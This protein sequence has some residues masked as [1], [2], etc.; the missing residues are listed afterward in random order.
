MNAIEIE[1]TEE[2]YRDL[3]DEIYGDV[4]VCGM[5]FS[6]GRALQELDPV[7]F[8]CGLS[9]YS[10]ENQRWKCG[11]CDEEFDNEDDAEACCAPECS[12]CGGAD[13]PLHTSGKCPDCA[14]LN[15]DEEKTR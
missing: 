4:E 3:L 12:E 15:S 7:A 6:S 2:Q 10:S 1:M 13:K 9:D 14:P 11:E 8:R 5:T